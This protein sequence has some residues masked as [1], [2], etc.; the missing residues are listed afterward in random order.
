[1]RFSG[2]A[3]RMLGI[4]SALAALWLP[5]AARAQEVSFA[6]KVVEVMVNFAAGS[7][8]D[9][10][11]RM[12]ATHLSDHL[13]GKPQVIVT[14]RAGAGGTAA[15]DYL[16][17]SVAPD[18][19]VICYFSGT[20]IRWAL[21]MEQVPAGTGELPYVVSKS[22]NQI[23][24]ARKDANLNFETLP[25]NKERL[26][27]ASNSPDNHFAIR[28]RLLA[29][30]LGIEN[31][32]VVTGYDTQPK[33]LAAV[34]SNEV[35]FAQANDTAFGSSR[36]ALLGDGVMVA[37]AQMGE[38]S[39]GHIGPQGGLEE[40]PVFDTLWRSASPGTVD[41]PE[42]RA[43]EALHV[44]MTMQNVFALPPATPQPIVDAW[45]KALLA[46]YADPRYTDQLKQLG[47]PD[48]KS[49]G[50]ADIRSRMDA[51]KASFEDPGVRAA[52]EAAI[53]RNMK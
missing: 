48:S 49:L 29:D 33:M 42:Y 9:S 16:I 15:V 47:M 24:L 22:V 51:A 26:F 31:L 19:I 4:A 21:G 8:T 40:I 44:V 35:T 2:S 28:M 13:P 50:A 5:A 18:G 23:V 3:V 38:Y 27:L 7:A 11:A 45:E 17:N 12:V 39:N 32:Q 36:D 1:M 20:P 46:A 14:N 30:T 37:V 53:A 43:W 41:S 6:G 52:I 34:R 10:A 25:N